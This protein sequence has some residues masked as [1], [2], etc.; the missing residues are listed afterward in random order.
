LRCVALFWSA[1]LEGDGHSASVV[2]LSDCEEAW[3]AICGDGMYSQ[4]A[5]LWGAMLRSLI[6]LPA[7]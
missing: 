6:K 3:R 1:G 7:V 2:G 4:Q 5:E